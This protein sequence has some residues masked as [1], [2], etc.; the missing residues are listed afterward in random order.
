MFSF[1]FSTTQVIVTSLFGGGGGCQE[2]WSGGFTTG[3]LEIKKKSSTRFGTP[4]ELF[5]KILVL[6]RFGT[7]VINKTECQYDCVWRLC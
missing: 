1:L 3:L 7:F 6:G 2:F 5:T 4:S